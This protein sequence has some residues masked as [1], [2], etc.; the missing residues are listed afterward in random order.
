MDSTPPMN[1]EQLLPGKQQFRD[2][3]VGKLFAHLSKTSFERHGHRVTYR[4]VMRKVRDQARHLAKSLKG[5]LYKVPAN[6]SGLWFYVV[7]FKPEHIGDSSALIFSCP[8]VGR[9]V[10]TAPQYGIYERLRNV[11][12]SS[13]LMHCE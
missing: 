6:S 13:F 2:A 5:F 7:W 10:G 4:S 9:I 1:T 12:K 11:P 3:K 8:D